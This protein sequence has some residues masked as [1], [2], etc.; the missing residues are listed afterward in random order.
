MPLS[1][2]T[3]PATDSKMSPKTF[4]ASIPSAVS[5]D[6]IMNGSAEAYK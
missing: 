1:K 4:G 6:T 3:A 5:S 2:N